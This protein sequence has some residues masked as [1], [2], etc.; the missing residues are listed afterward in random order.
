MTG[1]R[2]LNSDT[3]NA[4][5]DARIF[6]ILMCDLN[7]DSG[8]I[9]LHTGLG[10][11]TWGGNS[12][13]GVGKFGAVSPMEEASDLSRTPITL[14][15]S[16]LPNDIISLLATTTVQ[17]RL[18]TVYL[19]YLSATTR[20]LVNDPG[21]IYR[22]NIDTCKVRQGQT[23]TISLSIESRFAAWSNPVI[24]RFNNSY[25]QLRFPGDKGLEYIE[26]TVNKTIWWGRAKP[27]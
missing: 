26:Q 5:D 10:T 9:Y 8:T 1:S 4:C 23:V 22:G 21:I 18:A 12:Y 11:L 7:F 24:R 27:V 3:L 2:T 13:V 14:T 20:L 16:G 17:G 15:L 6:P 19:G 25:Q